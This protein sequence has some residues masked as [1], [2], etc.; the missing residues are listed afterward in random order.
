MGYLLG[1]P[2][3]CGK[4]APSWLANRCDAYV[5]FGICW[6]NQLSG[7]F[8][9]QTSTYRRFSIA[10]FDY[11]KVYQTWDIDGKSM[12][13]Y[14]HGMCVGYVWDILG[15][16]A[17]VGRGLLL[18]TMADSCRNEG[19]CQDRQYEI[20]WLLDHWAPDFSSP[21]TMIIPYPHTNPLRVTMV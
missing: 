14:M 10:T 21:T 2:Q 4:S 20:K 19:T 15:F 18:E 5:F 8:P 16:Q 7:N 13:H 17:K 12:V 11:R 9:A 6:G 1:Y 3:L